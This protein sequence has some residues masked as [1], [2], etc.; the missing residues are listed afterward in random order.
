MLRY[1]FY[2]LIFNLISD[3]IAAQNIIW[4]DKV[5]SYSSQSGNKIYSAN[6][7][8][9]KPNSLHH[10]ESKVAWMP[11]RAN[12]GLESITVSYNKSIIPKSII[13]HENL[14]PGSIFQVIV[15]NNEKE[16][17]V[18]ENKKPGSLPKKATSNIFQ[19]EKLK[20]P[21]NKVTLVL[22]TAAVFG[23]NQID[24]IGISPN[25][26]EDYTPEIN[27]ISNLYNKKPINMGSNINSLYDDMLPI[28]SPDGNI[29]FFARKNAPENVGNKK[30][31]DIYFS[32]WNAKKKQWN[33][34]QNIGNPLNNSYHNFVVSISPDGNTLYLSGTYDENSDRK[35]VSYS[36]FK[37]GKWSLPQTL[38]IKTYYNK[39]KYACYH[40]GVDQ[41]TMLMALERDD[42]YGD[43]D[44][45]I[46]H[47]MGGNNWSAPINLG[48]T[49]NTAGIE[50]SV[51]LA[52]DGKTIYFSS[53][54]HAGYGGLDMFMSKRLDNSW[55]K[56]TEPINLGPQINTP[57]WDVYYTISASGEYAFFS[58]ENNAIGGHDI[59][60][61]EL[62][63]ELRPEPVTIVKANITLENTQ[64]SSTSPKEEIT[65]QTTTIVTADEKP[66]SLYKSFKGYFPLE[67]EEVKDDKK[68]DK[69][70]LKEEDD[71]KNI[72]LKTGEVLYQ[73]EADKKLYEL[74]VKLQDIKK[75]QAATNT[76]LEK[77]DPYASTYTPY[78]DSKRIDL[79]A[80]K[81]S[82]NESAYISE[83][84]DKLNRL[85]VAKEEIAYTQYVPS[86]KLSSI[87]KKEV[88]LKES[89]EPQTEEVDDYTKKLEELK[90][91]RDNKQLTPSPPKKYKTVEYDPE[92]E[93]FKYVPKEEIKPKEDILNTDPEIEAYRKKLQD[94]K[95]RYLNPETETTASIPATIQPKDEKIKEVAKE[96]TKAKQ[97]KEDSPKVE[98]VAIVQ[99]PI[100]RPTEE[101]KFE[102]K[103][104]EKLAQ[105]KEKL[106]KEN[107][108]IEQ[109]NADLLVEQKKIAEEKDKIDAEKSRI[110]Q[111]KEIL[112][113]QIR[114]L[115]IE[116]EKMLAD[117]KALETEKQKLEN[118]KKNQALEVVR[119][120]KELNE[121]KK[122]KGEVM[123]TEI[124]EKEQEEVSKEVIKDIS[125]LPLK[126]GAVFEIKNIFFNANSSILKEESYE[127]LDKIVAFLIVNNNIAVEI[128]GH[129]NG[130]C[131]DEFCN[132]LSASRAKVVMEYV[133]A[134]GIEKNRLSHKGYGKSQPIASNET[135]DGRKRNQRVELKIME[136]R[137]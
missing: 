88:V 124:A 134:E 14:N 106:L 129:T 32:Q 113:K 86:T 19:V 41:K 40:I 10:E 137:E 126:V 94:I 22:N 67:T 20:E 54:G 15:S 91:Q 116:R 95:E 77:Y 7:I 80:S 60:Q 92:D 23:F 107:E 112:D 25:K 8:L 1:L 38:D 133:A 24:A 132:Q 3:N 59:F 117:K 30:N 47:H 125:L 49:I 104:I 115:E 29:I 81:K 35:G 99:N 83:L 119:L 2:I 42:S 63:K 9:G 31:D 74:Q 97:K 11:G 82:Y 5:V 21:I 36:T 103:E 61:I 65:K 44:L 100:E 98:V 73:T 45:Y 4:A 96:P 58:S 122:E 79:E 33:P 89:T 105:Q 109:T 118:L 136:I 6:Q 66:T 27:I 78:Q 16:W 48:N 102:E 50:A 111:E 68:V 131:T 70:Y 84:E 55:Q 39:S 72:N 69:S 34:A 93:R 76:K 114:E 130:L 90:A 56:W 28:L 101:E 110:Q 52:A 18:F 135:V 128:G 71:Y 46:S 13:V 12:A 53:D 127:E 17:V 51:F 85:K 75:E 64:K 87:P 123:E 43:M 57:L 62:P 108:Q 121:I 37:N 120:Q 26:I